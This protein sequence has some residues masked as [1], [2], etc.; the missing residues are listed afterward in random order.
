MRVEEGFLDCYGYPLPYRFGSPDGGSKVALVLCHGST[1]RGME[2]E[3]IKFLF[4]NLSSRWPVLAFDIPGFGRAPRVVVEEVDDYL[5]Y[6]PPLAAVEKANE[7]TGLKVVLIGHSM[8]GRISLQAASRDGGRLVAG[9]ITLAGLY[10]LP[11][12]PDRMLLLL[13]DFARFVKVDFKIPLRSLAQQVSKL[14]PTRRAI[15]SLKV[16]LLAI[17]AG[18]EQYGF[19]RAT[20]Y[21]LFRAARCSKTLVLVGGA[22]HKFKGCHGLLLELITNWLEARFGR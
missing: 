17:E 8:G 22:D 3:L 5:F 2:H 16:H 15:E 7:L 6:R 18:R 19:M 1:L 13:E 21:E 12:D 20:R 9:V 4:E 11:T 10:E 14:N